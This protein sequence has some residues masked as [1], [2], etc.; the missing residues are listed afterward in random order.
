M[1]PRKVIMPKDNGTEVMYATATSVCK[2]LSLLNVMHGSFGNGTYVHTYNMFA[3]VSWNLDSEHVAGL[4]SAEFPI[5]SVALCF[6]NR[7]YC[8]PA[9]T[10]SYVMLRSCVL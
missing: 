3:T 7:I 9:I 2:Y 10:K 4:D 5:F 1:D 6:Y 8:N